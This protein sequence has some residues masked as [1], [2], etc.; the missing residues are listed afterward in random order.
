[1]DHTENLYRR[2]VTNTFKIAGQFSCLK[3]SLPVERRKPILLLFLVCSCSFGN[4]TY[5]DI[6]R[7]I[8]LRFHTFPN[9]QLLSSYTYATQPLLY[10][11][12]NTLCLQSLL[13]DSMLYCY[14]TGIQMLTG[15]NE[16]TLNYLR[17]V[18][19][20]CCDNKRHF[21]QLFFK[22]IY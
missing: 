18:E 2:S 6:Q 12:L 21:L 19:I 15:R 8:M 20:L 13:W 7:K 3:C 9:R 22:H 5:L 14:F 1:M 11:G 17:E 16:T 10:I 4:L